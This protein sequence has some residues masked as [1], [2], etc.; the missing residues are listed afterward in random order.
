MTERIEEPRRLLTRARAA[1]EAELDRM[2]IDGVMP[3]DTAC[4]MAGTGF[5]A[6]TRVLSELYVSGLSVE[7]ITEAFER[8]LRRARADGDQWHINTSEFILAIWGGMQ[9]DLVTYLHSAETEQR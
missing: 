6:V 1:A 5:T 7:C 3:V 9:E 2:V 4:T 8:N